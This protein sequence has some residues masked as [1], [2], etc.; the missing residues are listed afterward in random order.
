MDVAVTSAASSEVTAVD[1]DA[2]S[3]FEPRRNAPRTT[4]F[5]EL[6]HASISTRAHTISKIADR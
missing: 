4:F 6:P 5:L 2:D 3:H 1:E